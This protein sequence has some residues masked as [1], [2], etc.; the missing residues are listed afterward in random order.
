MKVG[1]AY[2]E[3]EADASKLEAQAQREVVAATAGLKAPVGLQINEAGFREE[4]AAAAK[5]AGAGEEVK[6]A[7][8]VDGDH[9]RE[10]VRA[11]VEGAGAGEGIRIPVDV[12]AGAAVAGLAAVAAAS[13]VADSEGNGLTQDAGGRWRNALG[14]FATDAEKAAAGIDEVGASAGGAGRGLRGAGDAAASAGGS[15]NNAGNGFLG[16]SGKVWALV[17]AAGEL[18]PALAALPALLAGAGG[19]V[20]TLGLAFSSVLTTMKDH[21][22]ASNAVGTSSAQ[23]AATAQSNAV[24]IRNAEQSISDAKRQSAIA[25]QNSAESIASAQQGVADAY[26]QAGIASASSAAQIESAQQSASNAVRQAAISQQSSLDSIA[27]AEQRLQGAQQSQEQAQRSLNIATADATNQLID[28]NNAAA[29][30]HLSAEQAAINLTTAEQNLAAVQGSSLSNPKQKAQAQLDLAKAQ[31]AVADANQKSV[32]ATQKADTANKTGADGLPSVV[33]AQQAYTR[34]VQSTADA[35]HALVVAERTAADQKVSSDLTV[36]NSQKALASAQT[37]AANQQV[38][39]DESIA[40]SQAGLASAQRSADQQKVASTEAVAN[41]VQ[42]L[43]DTQKQQAL[44]A[45]AS[46]AAAGAATSKFGADMAKASPAVQE[47]VNQLLSMKPAF[48]QLKL[49]AE[50]AT[51]PGFTQMLR[52]LEPMLPI[53]NTEVGNMGHVLG[54][55]AVQFG[56]LF[57]DPAFRGAFAGVLQQGVTLTQQLGSGFV[58]MFHGLTMAAGPA[59]PIV[60]AIGRGFHDLLASGIPAFFQGLTVNASGAAGGISGLLKMVGDLLGPVGTLAGAFSGALGPAFADLEPD[61]KLLADD[62]LNA[63]LPVMPQLSEAL[64]AAVDVFDQLV[65]ILEP[66]IPMI[67][68]DL[69]SGLR[70]ITPLLEGTA[71]FLRENADWLTPVAVGILATVAAVKAWNVATGLA[72]TAT[73]LW[74]KGLGLFGKEAGNAAE[75]VGGMMGKVGGA[76]PLIGGVVTGV[77]ALAGWLSHLNDKEVDV[78]AE[79]IKMNNALVDAATGSKKS[80]DELAALAVTA[81]KMG[82]VGSPFIAQIDEQLAALVASGHADVAKASFEAINTSILES[83]QSIDKVDD[84]LTQY[85]NAL[86]SAAV[87]AREAS[88]GSDSAKDSIDGVVGSA[89]KADQP[90]SGLT[91]R[92]LS[93]GQA[94]K[95]SADDL[96]RV[97]DQLHAIDTRLSQQQALDSYA[98]ALNAIK[99]GAA[100]STREISG[101]SQAALDNRN[102]LDQAVVSLRHVYDQQL[103]NHVPIDQANKDFQSQVDLL[104]QQAEKTYG[105]KDAVDHFLDSLGLVPASKA[106]KIDVHTEDGI[107]TIK[108]LQTSIDAIHGPHIDVTIERVYGPDG[109]IISTQRS[110]GQGDVILSYAGSGIKA[111]TNAGGGPVRAGELSWVGEKGPELVQFG[112]D[113]VVIPNDQ[114]RQVGSGSAPATVASKSAPAINNYFQYF[115]TQHPSP[116]TQAI[117]MRQLAL[118]VAR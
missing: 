10:E 94:G 85:K 37:A 69:S 48:D 112:R 82:A 34:S 27:S 18:G 19:A 113:G 72:K 117:M 53:F 111:S 116:E 30:A 33:S 62:I 78:T 40:K 39:S 107:K 41:A 59:V 86:G 79:T 76:I 42:S 22:A 1:S 36:A 89:S 115:G 21:V 49:T 23:L 68:D 51:L 12:D 109:K 45:A 114:I 2:V 97:D 93:V 28:L 99:D 44:A 110:N 54:D 88:F 95:N 6:I 56:T 67:A 83:G 92:L 66:L 17:G 101:N 74:T 26:R 70:D 25:T 87:S 57:Q 65:P 55:L 77:I 63:L 58:E 24:A 103:A 8:G 9:L 104:R 43:A 96:K 4:I 50:T 75:K 102:Q 98:K 47:M 31:Q 29:D 60:D 32:E 106:T 81:T 84:N 118:A 105:S 14:Q 46:A 20:G 7:V 52:D 100:G 73:D 15:A 108:T 80:A 11:E 13:R 61:V 64:H 3:L 5:G 16:L 91:L 71:K 90:F 38:A 35:Q